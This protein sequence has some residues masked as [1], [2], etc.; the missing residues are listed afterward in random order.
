[1]TRVRQLQVLSG[2]CSRDDLYVRV[3]FRVREGVYVWIKFAARS[4]PVPTSLPQ[5]IQGRYIVT[6]GRWGGAAPSMLH[7]T[8][9]E[10]PFVVVVEIPWSSEMHGVF[11]V[12]CLY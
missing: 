5:S 6:P 9:S 4:R 11:P 1:M 8:S 3:S 12:L 10:A 7:V 2:S